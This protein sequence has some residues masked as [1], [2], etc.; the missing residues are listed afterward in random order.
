MLSSLVI[1]QI[2]ADY[3]MCIDALCN[4]EGLKSRLRINLGVDIYY[5]MAATDIYS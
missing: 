1:W 4:V 3:L 5:V 2:C